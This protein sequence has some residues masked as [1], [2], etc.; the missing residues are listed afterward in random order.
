MAAAAILRSI[1]WT[2]ARKD[3]E[4]QPLPLPV[5]SIPTAAAAVALLLPR[6]VVVICTVY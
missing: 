3:H 2:V 1:G 5:T 6:V 4:E